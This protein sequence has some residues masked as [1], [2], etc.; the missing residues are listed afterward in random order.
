MMGI[1]LEEA[2]RLQA[3]ASNPSAI[4]AA[5]NE[6]LETISQMAEYLFDMTGEGLSQT[7][8]ESV[9]LATDSANEIGY[10]ANGVTP[11][12]A[13]GAVRVKVWDDFVAQ[14][15]KSLDPVT[16]RWARERAVQPWI[17]IQDTLKEPGL[18]LDAQLS[19]GYNGA[20][21]RMM[22]G[23]LGGGFAFWPAYEVHTNPEGYRRFGDNIPDA[24][25]V[26]D[27]LLYPNGA[28]RKRG[29]WIADLGQLAQKSLDHFLIGSGKATK[30]EPLRGPSL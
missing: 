14:A 16:Q 27:D 23:F 2:N 19:I 28:V 10:R 26:S 30:P 12:R 4:V 5:I 15:L 13:D 11:P 29:Y 20:N 8:P 1:S 18:P 3:S 7:I 24:F 6:H 17:I 25:A 9:T 21:A 22:N